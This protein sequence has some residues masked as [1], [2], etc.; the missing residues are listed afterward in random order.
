MKNF[1]QFSRSLFKVPSKTICSGR[2]I[3]NFVISPD[4]SK[5][6]LIHLLLE[7]ASSSSKS[8][9]LNF[10]TS[11]ALLR[12]KDSICDLMYGWGSKIGSCDDFECRV[13]HFYSLFK[14]ITLELQTLATKLIFFLSKWGDDQDWLKGISWHRVTKGVLFILE[15][16]WCNSKRK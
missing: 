9:N 2:K 6:Q 10:L 1:C 15:T 13:T 12:V 11:V 4:W 16:L 14:I 3:T 5:P 7:W 8:L